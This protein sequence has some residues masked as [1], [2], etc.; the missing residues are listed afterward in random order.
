MLET[1]F[2]L[3]TPLGLGLFFSVVLVYTVLKMLQS[4]LGIEHCQT[5]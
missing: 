3:E 5:F 1:G 2:I 4:S